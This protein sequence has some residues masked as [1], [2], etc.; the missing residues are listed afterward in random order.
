MMIVHIKR[1]ETTWETFTAA[2]EDEALSKIRQQYPRASN[3]SSGTD[4]DRSFPMGQVMYIY[5]AL[6]SIEHS[7]RLVARIRKDW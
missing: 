6:E 5:E 4:R 1:N 7:S 2:T 3:R